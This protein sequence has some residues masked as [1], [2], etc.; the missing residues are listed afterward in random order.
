M[1]NKEISRKI[2]PRGKRDPKKT[3]PIKNLMR[4]AIKLTY[5]GEVF[6]G[7]IIFENQ[8]YF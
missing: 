3:I 7:K 6:S 2:V 8:F 4:I 1:A 5:K